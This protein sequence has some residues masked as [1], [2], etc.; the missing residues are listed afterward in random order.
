MFDANTPSDDQHT[1]ALVPLPH[2]AA[3]CLR[4]CSSHDHAHAEQLRAGHNR[5]RV[6]RLHVCS[7]R[8]EVRAREL[9]REAR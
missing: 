7:E 4:A 8:E 2:A 6:P 9:A 5:R 1:D 3:R